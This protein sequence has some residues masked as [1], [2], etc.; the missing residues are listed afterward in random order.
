VEWYLLARLAAQRSVSFAGSVPLLIDD[1]LR[2]LESAEVRHLLD[3]LERMAAAVQVI[4]VS[5]DPGVAA[6][7]EVAG[8]DRAAVVTPEPAPA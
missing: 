1:A 6:W 2:G 4:Y 8:P 5:D 7:A 3:R